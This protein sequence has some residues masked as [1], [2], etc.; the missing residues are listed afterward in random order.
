MTHTLVDVS[1][2]RK[3]LSIEIPAEVVDA[4]IARVTRSYAKSARVPGFRPG[5]VPAT[6]A[7]QRFKEQILQDVARE[8]VPKAV[9]EALHERGVEPVDSPDVNDFAIDEGKPLTFMATFETV[10]EFE[11]GD[12]ATILVQQPASELAPD[13]V[14]AALQ[15]LRERAARFEPVDARPAADGDTLV[16]DIERKDATGESDTHEQVS[17]VIGGPGNPPGFDAN[18]VG[19]AAGETKTFAIHFPDDYP[20]PQLAGTDVTY[21]VQ[22]RELRQRVLPELDDE[23]AKDVG[24]FESLDAL[25]T[26]VEADLRQESAA[27]A[28]RAVRNSLLSQLAQRIPFELPVSL[29]EREMDRRVEEFARR[30]ME[31]GVDPRKAGMDWDEFRESQRQAAR[32][33]VGSAIALDQLARRDQVNVE[34]DAVTSEMARMAEAIQ[35]TP[36]AVQAQLAKDGGLPRLVMGMRREKT[37]EHA[38]GLITLSRA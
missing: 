27:N 28:Q 8:L 34:P 14:S 30:L 13:A 18:L 37:V 9:D 17:L 35:R 33:A 31:Q 32:D 20:V 12:L 2:T 7:R 29:V 6:V 1:D 11:V 26:R 5:K 16:A 15:Q 10:P 22:A 21:T 23:F 25:R 19:M 38:L 3:Q 36:E 4:S 24:D